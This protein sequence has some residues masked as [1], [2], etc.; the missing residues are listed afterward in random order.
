MIFR[1]APFEIDTGQVELR[2]DGARVAVEPQVF[3]L[4]RL[5]VENRERLV[6]KD[7]II[8]TVWGGRIVS[9]SALSSRIKFARQALDDDG[10]AQRWIRT[11]HGQGFRFVGEAT[12]EGAPPPVRSSAPDRLAEVMARP[13]VAVFPFEQENPDP[14]DTYFVDGLAEDLMAELAS[15]RWF[16]I[17]SR[18]AAFDP[19]RRALPIAERAAAVGA[20]YAIGGRIHRAGGQARLSIELLDAA[21]GEQLWSARFES[22]LEG[23]AG[24][25]A[26]I[27]RQVFQRIAPE[28]DSA[29]RRRI[30]RKAPAD[31]TAW[32]LTMK[33]LWVLNRPSQDDFAGAL[34]Q[35]EHATELDPASPLSWALISLIRYEAALKGWVG[36][37]LGGVEHHFQNMLFAAR[38]AIEIDPNGWMGHSLAGAGELW[39]EASHARARYHAD[40]AIDLN[41]SA[42]LAHHFS[43][44]IYGF[45]G[46]PEAAFA[47]QSQAFR[48]DPNYLHADVIEADLGL[49]RY[50]MDDCEGARLHLDRALAENP[51]NLR[52]RQRLVA[53]LGR[54][55]DSAGA[56]EAL[57]RLEALGGPLTGGYVK[58]S[59]PFQQREHLELFTEG[60]RR[61]GVRLD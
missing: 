29:E 57:D 26:E 61:G 22:D 44:C 15:W 34:E 12:E 21:G 17:L 30:L 45:G 60:L 7:E 2:R 32:D 10:A 55:G 37:N 27:A 58:A 1:F 18:N 23:L 9:E 31:L 41:P 51:K 20:R 50:L 39:G 35:L 48:V 11:V 53:V 8:E 33:A 40:Q 14:R 38:K 6:T 54:T 3:A 5:L 4:L 52:A 42:G 24:M 47:T 16:P 49:W 43:G 28:L 56:R 36:G 46:D 13:M 25:Q 59:Y 19:A